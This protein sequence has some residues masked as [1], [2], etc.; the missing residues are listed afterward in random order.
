METEAIS[1][2]S[3]L[4]DQD[5][6]EAVQLIYNSKGRVIITGVGKSAI[7][8]TKI[9]ATLNSTGTPSVFMHAADAIH[10][11]LG[12]I[13][14]DDVVICISKSGNT[15]EIKVLV[16]LIKNAQNKMIAITGKKDSFLGQQADFVL[17]AYVEKEA[18]PN[19]LAPTTSTTAQLVL[20]DALAVCLLKLR[21]FS[22]KDFAKYHPGGS[23]GKKLY[24]RVK[25]LSEVN[26]KP[27]VSPETSLKDVII[28]ISEK[29]LGVTAVLENDEI[30]GIITDG[31]LRRMLSK[32]ED[33]NTLTAKDIMSKNPKRIQGDAMAVDAMELMEENNISQLLV[34]KDGKY[35]GVVHI[36]DLVK[37]GIL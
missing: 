26:L 1:N 7:I 8:A 17:N 19:N 35:A 28:E 31:D 23:L 29:M 36:H 37:E 11:D 25:D 20:G 6:A 21:G 15:P 13:L 4:L 16:P 24:L 2:L 30:I 22:S 9:V 12:L 34:E 14:E 18:C 10:G 5:F 33:F 27:Q 3:Q 32:A